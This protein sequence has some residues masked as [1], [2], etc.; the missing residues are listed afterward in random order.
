VSEELLDSGDSHEFIA[1]YV[2]EAILRK[3]RGLPSDQKIA[4]QVALSNQLLGVLRSTNGGPEPGALISQPARLLRCVRT[5]LQEFSETKLP[6]PDIPLSQSDLLVNARDEPAVGHAL[7]KEIASAD[8]IDLLCAFLKWNGLR[9]LL[10]A[11][12]RHMELG[13][14]LRVITT[15]YIGATERRVLD[16]LVEIGA[17]VRVTY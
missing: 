4:H 5:A 6:A 12:K 8:R 9:I 13:R 17:Q 3:L 10:D 11:L 16:T 15:T 7:T 2:F 14:P 1:R